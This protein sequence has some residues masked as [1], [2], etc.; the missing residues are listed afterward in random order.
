MTLGRMLERSFVD[1]P[2]PG[3]GYMLSVQLLDVR[4]G[5]QINC[6]NCKIAVQLVDER[7]S[8]HTAIETVGRAERELQRAIRNFGRR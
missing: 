2:C 3:C 5:R 1:A 6:P 4:I 7:A 8:T